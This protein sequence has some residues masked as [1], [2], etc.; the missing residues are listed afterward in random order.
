MSRF[1]SDGLGQPEPQGLGQP[2]DAGGGQDRHEGPSR[3]LRSYALTRGRTRSRAS[4][5]S[6]DVETLVSVTVLGEAPAS[7]SLDRRTIVQLCQQ[8]ISVAEVSAYM[9]VPLGVAKVLLG[10]MADDGLITIHQPAMPN[11]RPPDVALL[12]R[13]LAGLRSL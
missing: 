5:S 7:L 11:H 4:S 3:R 9:D 10:D 6:L 12:E 13:V 8:P 2:T 1:P